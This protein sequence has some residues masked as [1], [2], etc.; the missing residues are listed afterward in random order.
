[1][2]LKIHPVYFVCV[3]FLFRVMYLYIV[4]CIEL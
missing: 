3:F 2:H 4:L 1:M